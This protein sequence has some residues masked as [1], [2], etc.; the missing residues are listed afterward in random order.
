MS[1]A[2]AKPVVM[3]RQRRWLHPVVLRAWWAAHR[4]AATNVARQFRRAPIGNLLTIGVI[5][6]ALALPLGLYVALGN[7]RSVSEDWNAHAARISLY[8]KTSIDDAEAVKFAGSLNGRAGIASVELITR[9]EALNEYRQ[10][11][12]FKAALAALDENPLP[13]VVVVDPTAAA[14]DG[15][16]LLQTLSKL[17]EVDTASLDTV[18]LRRLNAMMQLAHQGVLVLTGLLGV[19]VLL[20]VG[21]A[22]RV[23][24]LQRRDEIEISKLFGA[25]NAFVRRPFLYAGFIYGAGGGLVACLLVDLSVVAMR[26]PISDL[27]RLYHSQ[28]TPAGLMLSG[29]TVTAAGSGLLGLLGAWIAASR[30]IRGMDV[31]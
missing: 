21:N 26:G 22:I 2:G 9:E 30:H 16:Q 19:A 23:A 24:V 11:S 18:W 1:R 7:L 3:L 20:V 13:A 15:D 17:P 8:L 25:T 31:R 5:G 29:L 14:G 27:A 10:L 12:G 4:Q 28:F 6:V